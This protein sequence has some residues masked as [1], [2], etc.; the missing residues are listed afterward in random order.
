[1]I[2][3]MVYLIR[4]LNYY[5]MVGNCCGW[6]HQIHYDWSL[7]GPPCPRIDTFLYFFFYIFLVQEEGWAQEKKKK[8]KLLNE[9][10][11][12]CKRQKYHQKEDIEAL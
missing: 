7:N 2:K 3:D 4:N 11:E 8:T 10:F 6:Y 5:W 1:M 9:H 12:A